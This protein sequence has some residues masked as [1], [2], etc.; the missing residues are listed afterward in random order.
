MTDQEIHTKLTGIFRELF[1]AP[2]L[3]ISEATTARDV[4]G[5]D[6]VSH[7]DLICMVEDGFGIN[8]TTREVANL[9]NVGDLI[10]SIRQ[11]A[12]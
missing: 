2:A 12:S 8:L 4:A 6:S 9:A 5:W 7:I 1:N 11:K 3:E 10:A